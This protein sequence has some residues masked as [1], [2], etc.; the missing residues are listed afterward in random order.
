MEPEDLIQRFMRPGHTYTYREC[1]RRGHEWQEPRIMWF[2]WGWRL[3]WR[4]RST[5]KVCRGCGIGR[6]VSGARHW[7]WPRFRE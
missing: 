7:V 6:L 2:R 1:S 4:T 5:F 3:P